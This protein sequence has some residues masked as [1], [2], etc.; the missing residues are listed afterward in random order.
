M[1]PNDQQ[2]LERFIHRTLREMPARHA[3][4]TLEQ[5]VLAEIERRAALPWWHQSFAHWPLAARL[6]FLVVSA[7]LVGV[8]W[9]AT[10][11]AFAGF[12]AAQFQQIFATQLGW[13][14][15]ARVVIRAIVGFGE[16][17]LRNIPALWLYGSLA[18]AGALY[19]AFFG[20]GAAA[21]RSLY[22]HR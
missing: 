19:A 14:E 7:M 9:N 4:S 11:W 20:L 15:N 10:L 12:E 5:R 1:N 6:A 8:A 21:Y 3:P 16:I 13:I 18:V 2:K 17:I 22:A